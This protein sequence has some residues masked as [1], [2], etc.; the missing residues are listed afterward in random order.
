MI[1]RVIFDIDDTLIPWEKEYNEEIKNA[2]DELKIAHTAEDAQK[3]SEAL[4]EYE[5]K[6]YTFDKEKMVQLVNNYMNKEYP[7]ELVYNIIKRWEK[8][9][10]NKIEQEI[11]E[12]LEYLKSK[13]ELVTLTDWYA[14]SQG[15]RLKKAGLLKYFE[16]IYS[17][18]NTNRKPFKE[19][20]IRAIGTNKPEECVM[21]GDIIERD[22]KGA[23]NAGLQAIWYNPNN[24]E[25]DMEC[26]TISKIEKLRDIL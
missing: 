2:L 18:E 10:P 12:T 15:E 23:I 14:E 21:I 13:Y 1:K 8:C 24:K 25:K 20:F 6:W 26:I 16:T 7:K 11:I 3:I 4:V 22:V 9:A 17:A 5:N 19:A